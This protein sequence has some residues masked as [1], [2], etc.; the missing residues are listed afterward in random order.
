[1]N[2]YEENGYENRNEYLE[3]LDNDMDLETVKQFADMLGQDEDFDM[4][5]T[6]CELNSEW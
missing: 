3:C 5:V 2:I 1:M 6:V 4:L